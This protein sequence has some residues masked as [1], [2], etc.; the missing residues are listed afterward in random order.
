MKSRSP[1]LPYGAIALAL[2]AP[3]RDAVSAEASGNVAIT[4]DYIFRGLTQSWGRP[5]IQG[6]ADLALA[7]GLAVGAWASSV[8][9]NSYPGGSVELDLYASYGGAI[10]GDGAWRA[11]LYGYVYPGADLSHAGL[12]ARS[13]DTVEANL[14]LTWK[15]FTLK[16]N[17]ALTDY[18]GADVEQGYRSGSR[19]T[20]YAQLDAAFGLAHAW[21]LELHAG[22]TRYATLLAVPNGEGARKPDYAD[23]GV[24]LKHPFAGRW[25]VSLGLTHATHDRFYR[26][27]AS[28]LDASDVRNVGGTRA[29]VAVQGTF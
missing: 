3:G 1:I 2:L 22:Y 14:A 26:H 18:F 15:R 17:R 24:T 4:S 19:G 7:D 13:P 6:G 23:L 25:S 21:S 28:L 9:G 20:C 12:G 16:Y 8:S 11:G 29:F 27:T 5:A 10:A